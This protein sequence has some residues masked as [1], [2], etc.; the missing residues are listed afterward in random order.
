M[1]TFLLVITVVL[2]LTIG[3]MLQRLFRG[4]TIF[5]RM[6]GLGV[7]TADVILLI[8][9]F[10]FLDKQPG[11]YVDLALA[12]AMMGCLGSVVLGKYL[13]GKKL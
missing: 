13:G 5:D 4:P 8:V 2:L 7:I 3:L 9:I 6:N 10:G 11:M 12:Y 1:Q